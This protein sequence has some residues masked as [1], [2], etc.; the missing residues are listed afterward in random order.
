[1]LTFSRIQ[2]YWLWRWGVGGTNFRVRGCS[3][4]Q[5]RSPACL[6]ADLHGGRPIARLY[7]E[8]DIPWPARRGI[9]GNGRRSIHRAW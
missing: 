2:R 5:S 9:T 1:M 6:L 8:P 7:N 3:I 4:K